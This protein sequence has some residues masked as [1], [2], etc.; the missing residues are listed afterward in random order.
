M[1]SPLYNKK[2]EKALLNTINN[3][4]KKIETD[5]NN[6][7]LYFE[8]ALQY[9]QLSQQYYDILENF[10]FFGNKE[11][12]FE[13]VNKAYNDV[14]K[15][16]SFNIPIDDYAYSFKLLLLNKLKRWKDLV[17]YGKILYNEIGCT[18]SDCILMGEGYFN[19]QEWQ[20]C[21]DFYSFAIDKTNDEKE[22]KRFGRTF[23]VERGIAYLELQKYEFAINDFKRHIKIN[24]VSKLD[25]YNIYCLMAE[26]YENLG[27]YE[28]ALKEYSNA[29]DFDDENDTTYFKRGTIYCDCLHVYSSAVQD[30]E[31]AININKDNRFYYSFCAYAYVHKGEIDEINDKTLALR[32]Y[33]KAIEYYKIAHKMEYGDT[34]SKKAKDSYHYTVDFATSHKE[35][36]IKKMKNIKNDSNHSKY[37]KIIENLAI[38]EPDLY[39][40]EAIENDPEYK[41]LLKDSNNIN[42]NNQKSVYNIMIRS[43]S[44]L[45]KHLK[46][47][48]TDKNKHRPIDIIAYEIIN[49]WEN[50]SEEAIPYLKAMIHLTDI[51][52]TYGNDSALNIIG[53]FLAN[54]ENYTGEKAEKL[55]QELKNISDT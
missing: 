42:L 38:E 40:F 12:Y 14:D 31:K 46:S 8:R 7:E 54:S 13:Y 11:L 6:P 44:L 47:N 18:K 33:E 19:L 24:G 17:K 36:L 39:D 4:T 27:D 16:L 1:L 3:I 41:K 32:D 10:D 15:A 55:K 2:K 29:L 21:I 45:S 52:D 26:A 20:K 25:K 49:D 43:S 30:F 51:D 48:N 28:Q 23:L 22:L 37:K 34:D 53:Y 35:E 9:Y 50:I 5:N